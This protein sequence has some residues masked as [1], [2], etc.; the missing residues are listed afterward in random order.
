V[1]ATSPEDLLDSC[2]EFHGHLGLGQALGVRLAL[3][4]MAL[5]GTRHPKRVFDGLEVPGDAGPGC[6]SCTHGCYYEIVV[7]GG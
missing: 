5:I 4:G 1:E 3:E 6:Q 7:N 2:V